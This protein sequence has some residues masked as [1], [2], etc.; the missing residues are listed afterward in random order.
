MQN[1]VKGNYTKKLTIQA[2]MLAVL[3]VCSQ[4]II[5]LPGGVPVTLQVLAVAIIA[6]YF[7]L[8]DALIIVCVYLFLGFI[9]LPFF[10]GFT[11]GP[12]KLVSP[13]AGYLLGFIPMTVFL[14]LPK[15]RKVAEK[16]IGPENDYPVEETK[17]GKNKKIY[18]VILFSLLGLL[19]CH[20]IGVIWLSKVLNLSYLQGFMV[21]SFPF[22]IK[23]LIS[24]F[25]A[26]VIMNKIKNKFIV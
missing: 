21:G 14:A 20:L 17:T 4:I 25:I 12:G 6:Y 5:P 24:L 16:S 2:L 15:N 13:S 8:K 18:Q 11:G 19:S 9:G 26:Y 7:H 23:D 10:S 3:I 22:L 1:S